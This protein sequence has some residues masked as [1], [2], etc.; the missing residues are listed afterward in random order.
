[1][2][3]RRN[4]HYSESQIS[5]VFVEAKACDDGAGLSCD[6]LWE[7]KTFDNNKSRMLQGKIFWAWWTK[8]F[9]LRLVRVLYTALTKMKGQ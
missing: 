5:C 1:M 4:Q 2:Y 8:Q 9:Y 7:S 6:T 3:K